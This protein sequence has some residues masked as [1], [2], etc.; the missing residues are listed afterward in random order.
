MKAQAL[1][2]TGVA[3]LTA[4]IRSS[5]SAVTSVSPESW[6]A[7]TPSLGQ[8]AVTALVLQDYLGG[9]LQRG[10]V[11]DTSHYWLQ[12]ARGDIIDLTLEQFTNPTVVP[13]GVR[14]RSYVLSS[15]STAARYRTLADAV[16]R[17]ILEYERS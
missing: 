14:D 1:K 8:C 4:A 2:E 3:D 12:T 6:T 16:V 9:E 10:L 13:T 15:E 7:S 11:G 5:W 17:N